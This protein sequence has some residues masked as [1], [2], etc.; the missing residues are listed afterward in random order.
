MCRVTV[1]FFIDVSVVT[2]T[3][4]VIVFAGV[5][6]PNFSHQC[7]FLLPYDVMVKPDTEKWP[8]VNEAGGRRGRQYKRRKRHFNM[9][10]N[11]EPKYGYFLSF[12]VG[13]MTIDYTLRLYVGFEYECPRGHRFFLSACD[14]IFK[15]PPNG[16]FKVA[17][18]VLG[19]YSN[20]CIA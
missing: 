13:N 8:M 9:R 3:I 10:S 17:A 18:I 19:S 7:N 12:S 14:K 16:I 2:S 4:F 5:E 11:I 20:T 1:R 15:A 6:Q